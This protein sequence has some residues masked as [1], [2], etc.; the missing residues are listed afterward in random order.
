MEH[1][2]K[3]QLFDFCK[4]F[5]DKRVSRI[6]KEMADFKE[7]LDDET[8]SSAGDKYETG[9]AMLQLELEKSSVQLAEAE[10]M[11]KVLDLVNIKTQA[12][13]IGL[14][15][16]VKTTKANYFLAI[17]AGEYKGDGISVYCISSETP[18]GKLL[19]TK[20]VNDV[21]NFNDNEIKILEIL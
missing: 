11:S 15:N 4:D 2:I 6:R 1:S 18:I 5:A 7:S 8:K 14:G 3:R 16:L 10:K 19:F 13:Y 17:S 20:Q 9:R 12:N 21:V